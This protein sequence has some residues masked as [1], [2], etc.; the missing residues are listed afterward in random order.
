M[1]FKNYPRFTGFKPRETPPIPR[2]RVWLEGVEGP[3]RNPLLAIHDHYDDILHSAPASSGNHQT[4]EGG[5][6]DHLTAVCYFAWYD[7]QLHS[8][9]LADYDFYSVLV[10]IMCH[11]AEKFVLYGPE[12]DPRCKRYHEMRQRG[13]SK[14]EVK[15]YLLEKWQGYFGLKISPEVYNAIKYTHGE[16]DDYQ[17]DR[18]VMSPL[19]AAVGNADRTSARIFF[20]YGRGLG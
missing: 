6:A 11:D 12:D 4:W 16:G 13:M 9:L 5:L 14:E 20:D 7:Y 2:L 18:R 3:E 19:A 10:A 15:W 1:S 17:S 8:P